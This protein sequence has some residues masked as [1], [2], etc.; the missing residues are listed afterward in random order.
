[1]NRKTSFATI[2]ITAIITVAGTLALAQQPPSR[3]SPPKAP[4]A[5]PPPAGQQPH[6]PPGW[7]D[8]DMQ[9]CQMAGTPGEMQ[10]RLTDSAGVWSG[11][12]TMWMAPN[13]E[14]MKTSSSST[15]TPIM[16]G[17]FVKCE[18]SGDMPEG[19]FNGFG[20]YGYDNVT[21]KFQCC[22][23]D[24]MSTTI[25]NGTGELSS[26]GKT[27][28]WKYNYTC[29]ITKKPVTMRE[30]QHT[31]GKD[32]RTLE[33]FT[34]DPKSGQEFKMLEIALTRTGGATA[35]ANTND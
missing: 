2:G 6:L 22:W 28:T 26:D 9:A 13:T 29:P 23:I 16:G 4:T 19:P 18:M 21:Q 14:P 7:T 12:N 33:M 3:T 31:T 20:L 34:T 8:S 11:K 25:M 35:A 10:K 27:M 32:T 30:V 17:R 24:N 5:T 1:M 15:I